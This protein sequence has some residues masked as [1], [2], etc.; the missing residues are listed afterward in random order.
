M[1]PCSTNGL[2]AEN[3]A[4]LNTNS[5]KIVFASLM[6]AAGI[7][8]PFFISHSLMLVKGNIFLLMY[9][10][11]I[12]GGFFAGPYYGVIC[13][14]LTPILS[15][16]LTAMPPIYPNSII[17]AADLSV[18]VLVSATLHRRFN[19]SLSLKHIYLSLIPGI[20]LGKLAYV[21][22]GSLLLFIHPKNL[23]VIA[24]IISGI[25]GIILQLSLIP[26]ILLLTG[27]AVKAPSRIEYA[28]KKINS[29]KA[30]LV[31]LKGRKIIDVSKS[32]GISH[33]LELYDKGLMKDAFVC[34]IIIGKAA[35]MIFY[36]GGINSCYGKTVSESA[37]NF[38]QEKGINIT[39]GETTKIIRNRKGTGMCPMEETVSDISDEKIAIELLREKIQSLR[40]SS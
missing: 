9:I 17:I 33:L 28:V 7:Y 18:L 16:L 5:K 6:L 30:S 4:M 21:L 34:D 31:L 11:V 37:L 36:A 27:K 12:I 13:A 10:P 19:H 3:K 40:S 32:R 23:S 26:A 25:P 38:L 2:R 29:G 8:L 35:A 14:V 1:F 39:Y 22:A 20:V 15:S 24:M